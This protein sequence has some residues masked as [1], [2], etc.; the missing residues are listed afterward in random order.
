MT[1]VPGMF[2]FRARRKSM[3]SWLTPSSVSRQMTSTPASSTAFRR[4]SSP[5]PS[6]AAQSSCLLGSRDA[7]EVSRSF[8]RS[9]RQIRATSSLSLFTIGSLAIFLAR[10]VSR[11]SLSVTGS[12]TKM[13][14]FT[15]IVS[16]VA[17]SSSVASRSREVMSP[18]SLPPILPFW[19]MGMPLQPCVSRSFFASRTLC[20]GPSVQGLRMKPCMCF[21]TFLIMAAWASG[22]WF[23]WT[24]PMPPK[25]ARAI[26]MS[27]SQTWSDGPAMTGRLMLTFFVNRVETPTFGAG[28]LAVLPG[29]K[30]TSL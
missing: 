2:A 9:P 6:A 14:S 20:R 10:M 21:F 8:L 22:V 3:A 4:S 1:S 29:R 16:I 11:A 26:A 5:T 25:S 28:A 24:M 7:A 30:T 19:V 17:L 18:T 27:S 15:I 23:L 13:T 12:W